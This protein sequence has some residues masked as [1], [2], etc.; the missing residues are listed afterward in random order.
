MGQFPAKGKPRVLWVGLKAP[1][2]LF[3][4][5]QSIMESLTTLGFRRPDHP[6]SPHITLA[7]FRNPPPSENVRPYFDQHTAFKTEAFPITDFILFSS[8][9]TPHR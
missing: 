9:L 3:T 5:Q 8:T 2:A 7:R 6:F 1:A 4:L